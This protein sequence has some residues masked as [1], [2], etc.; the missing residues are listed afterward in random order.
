[1]A[2]TLIEEIAPGS[3]DA[4]RQGRVFVN[5]AQQR[6]LY[7]IATARL[8]DE[9]I[10]ASLEAGRQKALNDLPKVHRPGVSFTKGE[11]AA[12]DQSAQLRQL[13]GMSPTDAARAGARLLA[14]RRGAR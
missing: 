11:V 3:S 6:G 8:G 10:R 5:S 4:I 1:M 12:A 14:Q 7:D 13:P 2:A 9:R